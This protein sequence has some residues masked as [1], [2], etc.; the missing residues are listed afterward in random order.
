VEARRNRPGTPTGPSPDKGSCRQSLCD[1]KSGH[2]SF[3]HLH[4]FEFAADGKIK[5]ERVWVDLAAIQQQL[6]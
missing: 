6:S 2:A 1:G 4:V 5:S 3:R